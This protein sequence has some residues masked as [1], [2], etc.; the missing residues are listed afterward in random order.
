[1]YAVRS[2]SLCSNFT[3]CIGSLFTIRYL[4]IQVQLSEAQIFY[5]VSIAICVIWTWSVWQCDLGKCKQEKSQC[6]N[7][8]KQHQTDQVKKFDKFNITL[9]HLKN[10]RKKRIEQLL[11]SW[12]IMSPKPTVF[13]SFC[14]LCLTIAPSTTS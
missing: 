3:D 2:V 8:K 4:L 5:K 6:E 12:K 1:M 14:P 9:E 13:T 11:I 7:R 10:P